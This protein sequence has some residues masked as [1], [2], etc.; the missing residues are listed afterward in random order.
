MQ[1]ER[2]SSLHREFQI[3][4]I[5]ELH[6]LSDMQ[7]L[8]CIV[9]EDGRDWDLLTAKSVRTLKTDGTVK[10]LHNEIPSVHIM[11]KL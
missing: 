5:F 7:C 8:F 2:Y 6:I 3:L 10:N 9:N 4:R 11:E 1:N